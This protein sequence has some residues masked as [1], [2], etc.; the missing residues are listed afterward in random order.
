M[1]KIAEKEK[2]ANEELI[3]S[4]H[5]ENQVTNVELIE[6][7]SIIKMHYNIRN[8]KNMYLVKVIEYLQKSLK[9]VKSFN[10]VV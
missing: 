8:V 3:E 9:K 1:E 2:I 4:I 5:L 10:E 7:I 6:I